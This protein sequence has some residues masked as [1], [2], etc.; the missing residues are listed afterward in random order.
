M[1]LGKDSRWKDIGEFDGV[2]QAPGRWG[3]RDLVLSPAEYADDGATE[4]L[5][6]FNAPG[7]GDA[8]G[9]YRWTGAGP[10][11]SDALSAL[12]AGSAAFDGTGTAQ[13]LRIPPNGMFAAGAAWADFSVEFWLSPSTLSDGE[14]VLSWEAPAEEARGLSVQGLSCL[15]SDR[16]LVWDFRGLFTRPD[17][18]RTSVSLSGTRRLLPRRWH[19]HL[20]RFDSSIG[21]LEYLIDGV[22]DAITH[23]T[24][25]GREGGSVALPRVGRG[26]PGELVIAPRFTGFLDELRVSRRFVEAPVVQRFPGRTGTAVSGIVDLGFT[27]TRIARIESVID[28]PA[29]TGVA[30]SYRISDVWTNPRSIEAAWVP[31]VPS[32]DFKDSV[33]GR[34]LQVMVEL[35]P[36]GT[37]T[38]TPRVSSLSIVYEPNLPPAPPAGFTVT[39][40]N[41]KVTLQWRKV[42][43]LNLKGYR[44]FYG[45]APHMYLGTG[46]AEGDSPLDAGAST[47]MV[48]TGLENGKLYYFAAAAYD[49]SDPPQLSAFSVEVSA[50]PSRMYP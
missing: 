5:F 14:T 30:F 31:F 33:R 41:G 26:H 18:S 19:H 37:R 3:F 48:I 4:M 6:H 17:G 20:L 27:G 21:L 49:D 15:I 2:A 38:R 43:D 25:T 22:P 23:V 44:V 16:R 24:D 11:I 13:A 46:A 39:P 45:D 7:E 40:G 1:E 29:D 28:T 10:R 42:N 12:G 34:Y 47:R 32:T 35:F 50:R 36:D 8:T 9:A